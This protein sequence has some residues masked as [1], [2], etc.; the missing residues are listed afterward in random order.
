[1]VSAAGNNTSTQVAISAGVRNA[2]GVASS[3]SLRLP[4][5]G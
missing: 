1:M 5:P 2:Q 3:G 4:S